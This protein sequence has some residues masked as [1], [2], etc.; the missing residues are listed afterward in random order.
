MPRVRQQHADGR[1]IA[2]LRR[3]DH[4]RNRQFVRQ[5][6]RVQRPA[7]AIAEQHEIAR[8]ESVLD[9]DLLRIAPAMITVAIEMHAVGHLDH[10]ASSPA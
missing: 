4:R 7:A 6:A 1:E 5:R 2:R 3:N 10:A 8:V 9:G